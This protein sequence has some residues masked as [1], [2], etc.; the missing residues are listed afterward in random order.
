MIPLSL[1]HWLNRIVP[2]SRRERRFTASSHRLRSLLVLEPLESRRV[3]STVTNLNDAGDGSLR[4]AII[5]TPTSGTIDF[6]D[7][8]SGTI[9]LTTGELAIN[10]DLTIVGPGLSVITVSGN[11]ASRVFSIGATFTVDISGLTIAN[12][13]TAALGGGIYNAGTLTLTNV[14]LRGNAAAAGGAIDNVASGNMT[15]TAST[16]SNNH[17]SFRLGSEGGGILNDGTLSVIACTLSGNSV[18]SGMATVDGGA[19]TNGGSM[20]ITAS[21][22]SGNN[23]SGVQNSVEGGAIANF[24]SASM[25]ITAS[26]IS[27]N[28]ATSARGASG[29]GIYNT[30]TVTSGNTIVA[31]NT[32]NTGPDVF[33]FLTSQ[34]YNLIGNGTSG[35]GFTDTDLVGTADMPIDPMLGP[36]RDNGGPTQTMALRPGGPALN[37]GDPAQLGMADQRGLV[38]TGGVNI[39]AYQASATAFV[40]ATPDTVSSGVPFDVT[41]TAV[42]PFGQVALGYTG[43]VTFS[44]TDLDPGVVLPADYTFTPDDQGTH[45]FTDTGLGE[46][47]LITPGVQT[48]TVTDT[49]DNTVT[50]CTTVTV[51]SPDVPESGWPASSPV[52]NLSEAPISGL[53]SSVVSV[54]DAT[55]LD[56]AFAALHQEQADR[57]ML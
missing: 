17:T 37:A 7:G 40:L 22:L 30:G 21:T 50:G 6:Q 1:R 5:D 39:G 29:G 57:C 3:P 13:A 38:R 11:G 18:N 8:L 53:T 45:T 35:S 34:G 24:G 16:L 10:K 19:I 32:A 4:Q 51:T 12:G 27:N 55:S 49:T 36:L 56:R 44:T 42:D 48:L 23:A 14:T 54:A 25:T 41:V 15:I 31:R 47:T 2:S 20:T 46:I 43:T 33:G 28:V 52:R 9:T 26:T